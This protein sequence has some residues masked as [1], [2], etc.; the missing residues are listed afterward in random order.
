[1]R[2]NLQ[3]RKFKRPAMKEVDRL[4][5]TVAECWWKDHEEGDAA[6]ELTLPTGYGLDGLNQLL[7]LDW[8]DVLGRTTGFELSLL[9]L[10]DFDESDE[11]YHVIK[12]ATDGG[13]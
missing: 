5:G 10:D 7:C 2:P 9:N 3:A 13:S 6:L 11:E 8:A 12:A 4:N 1:M